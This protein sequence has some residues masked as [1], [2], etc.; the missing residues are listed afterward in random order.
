VSD[1]V[2]ID[3]IVTDHGKPVLAT[4]GIMEDFGTVE[5]LGIWRE[6]KIWQKDIE[7]TLPEEERLFST[8]KHNQKIWVVDNGSCA[9]ILYPEEY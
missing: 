3:L 8:T 9:T 4:A 7:P 6:F 2:D 5:L 1:L